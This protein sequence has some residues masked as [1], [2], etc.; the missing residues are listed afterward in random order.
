MNIEVQSPIRRMLRIALAATL[1][2][3]LAACGK[4]EAPKVE[5]PAVVQPATAPEAKA[6]EIR[7]ET[8][9]PAPMPNPDPNAELAGKVKSALHSTPGLEALAVDIVAAEGVV[10]LF[11]TADTRGSLEKAGKI[12]S[13]VPG[14]KSVQNKIVVVQGS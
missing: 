3:G 2:W 9:E 8:S 11:G 6:G 13:D 4:E 1:V 7:T 10:T 5:Q 12:A 14:V